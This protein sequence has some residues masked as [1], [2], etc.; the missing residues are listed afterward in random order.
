MR[1]EERDGRRV[2]ERKVSL[3]LGL[4]RIAIVA[5]DAQRLVE[6]VAGRASACL[7]LGRVVEEERVVAVRDLAVAGGEEVAPER[8]ASGV[9]RERQAIRLRVRPRRARE[10]DRDDAFERRAGTASDVKARTLARRRK[11][12]CRSMV[13]SFV[14]GSRSREL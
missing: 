5:R 10:R 2:E 8:V 1:E 4:A 12:S 3:V 11:T 6:A 14:C 9:G 7:E 13:G